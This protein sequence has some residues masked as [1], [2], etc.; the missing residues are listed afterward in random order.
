M[1]V[2]TCH[3]SLVVLIVIVGSIK[4]RDGGGETEGQSEE[5]RTHADK[6]YLNMQSLSEFEM[7]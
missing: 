1:V 5:G 7:T 6:Y 4:E 3:C 2:D